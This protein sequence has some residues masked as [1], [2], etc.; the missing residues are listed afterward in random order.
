MITDTEEA[1]I[2]HILP[3]DRKGTSAVWVAQKV[4]DDHA[5]VVA[6]TFVIREVDF[7]SDDFK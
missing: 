1:W 7:N 2:F 6:N 5:A 3:S 4:P